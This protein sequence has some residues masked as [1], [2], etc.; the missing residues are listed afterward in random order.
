MAAWRKTAEEFGPLLV[1]FILNARGAQWF[2]LPESQSLFIATGGFM[3]ALAVAIGL[4]LA[5]GERP[6]NMTLF[7]GG[8]VFIFGGITLFL[9]DERFIKIKPTLVY[10][11]FAAIL[12]IG[13]ARGQSYLQRLM[14]N[15]LPLDQA[16]WLRL[17]RRWALFFVFL[18]GVN[19]LV[20]RTQS[21]DVWVNFKVFG[22]LP[23]TF[24]FMAVQLPLMR[25][26]LPD[27]FLDGPDGPKENKD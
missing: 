12:A 10:L 22:I 25:Q 13:L 21:T 14:G 23:L 6:N 8:F 3:V 27:G 2:G 16:G 7:S 11:L 20:W 4:T 26:H 18:A 24:L 19:E 17:T 15:M 1:F 9:Q 5:R